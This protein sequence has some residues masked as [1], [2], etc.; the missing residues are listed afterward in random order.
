M[1][2]NFKF[3]LA[4]RAADI[5]LRNSS[6]NASSVVSFLYLAF[7]FIYISNHYFRLNAL[8]LI[9]E[10]GLTLILVYSFFFDFFFFFWTSYF[11]LQIFKSRVLQYVCYRTPLFQGWH[12]ALPFISRRFP[13]SL[14]NNTIP[15][16]Q[17]LT[18]LPPLLN[19]RRVRTLVSFSV[20]FLCFFNCLW[21]FFRPFGQVPWRVW[22]CPCCPCSQGSWKLWD[23]SECGGSGSCHNHPAYSTSPF[24][25]GHLNPYIW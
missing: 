19:W 8:V 20:F 18:P 17:W 4:E 6:S 23:G 25:F 21:C 9:T 10:R 5:Y 2:F 16:S 7:F 3:L 15:P 14:N 22:H 13:Q 12:S 11:N 1:P 24:N